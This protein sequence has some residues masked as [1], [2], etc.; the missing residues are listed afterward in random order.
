MTPLRFAMVGCGSMGRRHLAGMGKLHAAHRQSFDLVAIADHHPENT[1]Q[2]ADL[3]EQTLDLR[4][5]QYASL[6]DVLHHGPTLDAL[7]ITTTPGSHL[8]VGQEAFAAGL[9]VLLEKP[10][11]LTIAA[12]R[13]LTQAAHDANRKLS[14]AENLRRDPINRLAK[15]LIDGGAV[16]QPFL[17][18]QLS[19][20]NGEFVTASPWRHQKQRGGIIIDLGVHYGDL[21]EYFLGPI[22]SVTGMSALIDR[23]RVDQNGAFHPSDSEDLAIGAAR[24]RSGALANYLLNWAG[25][26]ERLYHRTVYG[27]GGSLSI[28]RDRS[29]QALTLYQRIDGQDI[30]V[31]EPALLELVPDFALDDITATLFAGSRLTAYDLTFPDIDANLLA[32]EQAEFAEAI[33]HDQEPEVG[34]E[35]GLR[36]LAV[37]LGF[38]ES[39]LLGR[40]LT[41]DELLRGEDL[42]YQRGINA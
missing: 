41:M 42:P 8:E 27:T 24:Y 16:G 19:S 40:S 25:R 6:T 23:Q 33:L 3:A 14:I 4:P 26:G 31:P 29:G 9:H 32:I 7:L 11:T 15:A 38:L 10:I 2:G 39:N 5:Q 34:G 12:G 22:E 13:R 18:T 37:V 1:Q 20:S 36:G 21:L 28:P 17:M 35:M 30:L